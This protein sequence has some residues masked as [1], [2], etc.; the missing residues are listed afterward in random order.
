MQAAIKNEFGVT[1]DLKGGHSGI[2]DVAIDGEVVYSKDKTYRFPT[3][4]EIF[5]EIRKRQTR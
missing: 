4:D 3:N 2:F 1:A 5:A